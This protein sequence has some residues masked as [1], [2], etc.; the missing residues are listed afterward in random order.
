MSHIYNIDSVLKQ[1]LHN[2]QQH[3]NC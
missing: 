3:V 1:Q 2:A